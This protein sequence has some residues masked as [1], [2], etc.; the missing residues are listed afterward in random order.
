MSVKYSEEYYLAY[1]A[2]VREKLVLAASLDPPMTAKLDL[3]RYPSRLIFGA[4]THNYRCD[5][6]VE[7]DIQ[8]LE[9]EIGVPFPINF[10]TYLTVCGIDSGGPGYGI[11]RK[12]IKH[13]PVE[14]I[15]T[16]CLLEP[17][18]EVGFDL[19]DDEGGSN[20]SENEYP[21]KSDDV[22]KGTIEISTSGNPCINLLVVNG[23]TQGDVFSYTGD[24]LFYE[25]SFE[26]WYSRWLD[27]TLLKLQSDE[28]K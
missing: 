7:D 18:K 25:R 16:P 14:N 12:W 6:M 22:Y 24:M 15:K 28:V 27:E 10:R 13:N 21:F 23:Q 4:S 26:A 17:R 20:L 8:S 5:G 1:W 11:F 19:T 9:K 3:Y 2:E